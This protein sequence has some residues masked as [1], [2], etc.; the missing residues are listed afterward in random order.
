MC[1]TQSNYDLVVSDLNT[2]SFKR[3]PMNSSYNYRGIIVKTSRAVVQ[4]AIMS[5]NYVYGGMITLAYNIH[6][7]TTANVSADFKN[8]G[9]YIKFYKLAN[10]DLAII[11]YTETKWDDISYIGGT[12]K[13][14]D[15][16]IYQSNT[17]YPTGAT[18]ITPTA[19][20]T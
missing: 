15:I 7:A 20:P 13:S 11:A 16:E 4:L 8:M 2:I 17:A 5:N 3:L 18:E 1:F 10:E 6:N 19:F 9:T 14:T 12:V